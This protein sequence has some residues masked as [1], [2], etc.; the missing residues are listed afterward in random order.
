M[1]SVIIPVSVKDFEEG[2][3]WKCM[4]SVERAEKLCSEDVETVAVVNKIG[5]VNANNYGAQKAKG[6]TLVFLDADN[7][8]GS[9]FLNEVSQKS[10]NDYFIG[11]GVKYIRLS[12]YSLGTVC[13][14]IP[15]GLYL[16]ARQITIGAFWVRKK[17]FEEM[18]G[19]REKRLSD[20][21]FAV[22]LKRLAYKTDRKFESL[23]ESFLIWNTRKFDT[24]GD[25]HWLKGYPVN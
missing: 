6:E 23:K 2:L 13:F 21:D 22:R 7:F 1:I 19:F 11:G 25:W 3:L 8:V 4:Y 24:R 18:G 10:K 12:R 5:W 15:I 14:S 20:M 17:D 9:N 16:M